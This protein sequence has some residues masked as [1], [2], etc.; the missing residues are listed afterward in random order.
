MG[1]YH[2]RL[3]TTEK[4]NLPSFSHSTCQ[5]SAQHG[6]GPMQAIV[7]YNCIWQFWCHQI[8]DPARTQC[9]TASSHVHL[10]GR[11]LGIL[12]RNF[13]MER[14]FHGNKSPKLTESK[15]SRESWKSGK[16]TVQNWAEKSAQMKESLAVVLI[17]QVESQTVNCLF[18]PETC[19]PARL[20]SK[21]QSRATLCICSHLFLL[22]PHC[23]M[24]SECPALITIVFLYR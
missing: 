24:F 1:K 4:Q 6:S 8:R 3:Q 20:R 5:S 15:S 13:Y 21:R 11:H 14:S 10:E 19:L 7:S 23:Q 22:A 17:Y 18:C 2:H 12:L 9:T 16:Q